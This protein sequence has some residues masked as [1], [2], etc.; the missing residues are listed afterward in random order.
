MKA[1]V[2]NPASLQHVLDTYC[3]SSRQLV[4]L[5]KSSIFFSPS[6]PATSRAEICQE[7]HID[8]KALSDRYL[9]VLAL[10]GVNISD[11]FRHFYE[12][13]KERLMG[14]ME[15]QLSIGGKEILVKSV[16]Q[17]IPVFVISIFY[18]PKDVC[19]DITNLIA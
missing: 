3:Q 8:T 10:V 18:L 12:R 6:T 17:A 4:S 14:W 7:L 1:D 16:A 11:C 13:I 5:S 19:K 2:L 15:K 9:G